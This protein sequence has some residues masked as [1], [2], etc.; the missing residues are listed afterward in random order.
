MRGAWHGHEATCLVPDCI[1]WGRRSLRL[2]W[3]DF[4]ADGNSSN[5][6]TVTDRDPSE[7]TRGDMEPSDHMRRSPAGLPAGRA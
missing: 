1:R 2:E 7:P 4:D 3:F 6:G 5:D